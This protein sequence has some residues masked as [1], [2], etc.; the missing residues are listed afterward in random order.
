MAGSA[1]RRV[2][3]PERASHRRTVLSAEPVARARPLP[4]C[5]Q[6]TSRLCPG[7]RRPWSHL[8]QRRAGAGEG[9]VARSW[10]G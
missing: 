7:S 10:R 1:S 3:W 6:S 8:Q 2:H 4:S 5:M 9:A